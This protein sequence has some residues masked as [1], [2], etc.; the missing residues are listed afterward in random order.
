[1]A[2][3]HARATYQP[4]GTHASRKFKVGYVAYRPKDKSPGML[5][6]AR[7]YTHIAKFIATRLFASLPAR[8]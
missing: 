6:A 3:D 1:M 7:T 4:K 8:Q 2:S 5:R